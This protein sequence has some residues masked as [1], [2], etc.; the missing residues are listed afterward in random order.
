MRS[1]GTPYYLVNLQKRHDLR[2]VIAVK[3]TH[4][5]ERDRR[6][7]PCA[8]GVLA[9]KSYPSPAGTEPAGE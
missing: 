4:G 1:I 9:V 6:R 5:G 8:A 7:H 2:G 3:A